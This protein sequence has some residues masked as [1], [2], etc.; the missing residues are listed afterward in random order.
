MSTICFVSD[1]HLFASR[2]CAH[3][4]LDALVIAAQRSQHCILGGDIFDFR[5]STHPSEEA[6]ADAALGWLRDFVT[7]TEGCQVHFLLGNHDDHPLLH[8][9]LPR[10]EGESDRFG[11]SRFYHRLGNTLFLH[12]DVADKT[13]M[14]PDSLEL[15]RNRFRHGRRTPLQHR[16]YDWAV[17]A[18]L[19]RIAPPAVYPKKRVARRIL[20][21]MQHIGQGPQTGIEHVCFGHTHRPVDNY[22]MGNVTFHNCGAPIGS[23]KFRIVM[24]DVNPVAK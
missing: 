4:H 11:W 23:G 14:T 24:R 21:Y 2:S 8:A 15:Q 3:R 5:W 10:L 1:L 22:R 20:T 9:R 7:A 19:H 17:K 12:G 18:Q 13:M 16:I 6:T